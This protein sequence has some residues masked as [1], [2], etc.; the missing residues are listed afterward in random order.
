M[1]RNVEFVGSI[2]HP[3]VLDRL[4]A[5]V[6]VYVHPSREEACS[7]ALAEAL[8]IGIPAIGGRRSGGVPYSL[9]HGH[10]GVLVDLAPETLASAMLGLAADPAN[11]DR[12]VAR[13]R[14]YAREHFHVRGVA[15]RY[16]SLYSALF[17]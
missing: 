17:G 3:A 5:E 12:L 11:R 4:A 15:D 6:D 1:H 16:L 7:M 14:A 13:G 2:A 10:A 8:A 9:D